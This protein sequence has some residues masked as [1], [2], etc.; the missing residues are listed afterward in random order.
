M[1]GRLTGRTALV[2]GGVT[3][4]GRAVSL[5]L[6]EAG[7]GVIVTGRSH[8]E[9]GEDLVRNLSSKGAKAAFFLADAG[10]EQ[11]VARTFQK[12]HSEFGRLDILV[13]TAGPYVF[14]K[15][16]LVDY[17]K[18]TFEGVVAGNLTSV[19]LHCREA[20]P[21][22]A[23]EGFGRILNFAF[24]RAGHFPP[25]PYR[26]PYAAAKSGVVSLSLSLA[27]EVAHQKITVNVICPGRIVDPYKDASIAL[28]RQAR[29]S[30]VPIG[31]PGSG[32]DI[33]R[34]VCFLADPDADYL[35]G[36]VIN[37]DGGEDV[38]HE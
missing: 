21:L 31:R 33:A 27:R 26:A 5:A 37:V 14:E 9:A 13:N 11:D 15:L 12:I 20:I 25:W 32:E 24:D 35:T 16:S 29:S 18:D 7:A 8:A 6:S 2:T 1:S 3:G 10:S 30:K 4:L 23:R 38:L 22:M 28:A 19:F 36:N 17:D 34:V